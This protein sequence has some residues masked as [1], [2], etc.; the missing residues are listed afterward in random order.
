MNF[1]SKLGQKLE[2]R[3]IE[4]QQY[5]NELIEYKN[6]IDIKL[7]EFRNLREKT[8]IELDKRET[9]IEARLQGLASEAK[10]ILLLQDE[11]QRQKIFEK[12]KYL[13]KEVDRWKSDQD[14][15][16]KI[17]EKEIN[18]WKYEQ[19]NI[20]KTQEQAINKWKHEQEDILNIKKE[21]I[22]EWTKNEEKR[23]YLEEITFKKWQRKEEKKLNKKEHDINIIIEEK[24]IGFPW[25]ADIIAKYEEQA[26][27]KVA[28]YLEKKKLPAKTAA[29]NLRTI[30]KEKKEI[31]KKLVIAQNY[32]AYYES[33]F[34]WLRDYIDCDIDELFKQVERE[35][36]PENES[37]NED[38]VLK[39]MTKNEYYSLSSEKRNQL[40][41]DRYIKSK[42]SN[43]QIG[44][45]Y[46]RY[47]GYIYEKDGFKVE[48]T[49]IIEGLGDLGRDLICSKKGEIKIVQCKCWSSRKVIREKHINQLYGTSIKY[50]IDQGIKMKKKYDGSLFS[51]PVS[52]YKITPVFVTST[53]L[54]DVAMEF[55]N[56]L[57]IEIIQ[58]KKFESYPL[59]K[60]NIS[61]NKEK[62]YHLPIDQKYDTVKMTKHGCFYVKTVAEAEKQGFRR[63]YRW[64]GSNNN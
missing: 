34:P 11:K 2:Q 12:E 48:Y 40:A 50:M 54:S 27:F 46:E 18:K 28:K 33:L 14:N 7:G 26:E 21:E 60:C 55:A 53:K 13:Y 17:K 63:A 32:I 9:E 25:L 23:L 39:L 62:I 38:P 51:D 3:Y 44:R 1:L 64:K 20:L 52:E 41:L 16:L 6:K 43:W 5:L 56:M 24:T 8:I 57:E 59:I 10:N 47:I 58:E 22:N 31:K 15:V 4:Y 49:G 37:E 36:E 29:E 19:E 30:S 45:D 35:K 42:K 61:N